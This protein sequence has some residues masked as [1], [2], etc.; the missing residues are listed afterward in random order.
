M[1]YPGFKVWVNDD[2][3]TSGATSKEYR[4]GI[5]KGVTINYKGWYFPYYR[6]KL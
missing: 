4:A 2:G 1:C 3:S 6:V 5:S